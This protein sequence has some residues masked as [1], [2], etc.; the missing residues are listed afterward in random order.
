MSVIGIAGTASVL[1]MFTLAPV[2]GAVKV[3]TSALR[4]AVTLNGVR[5]HQAA[6][7]AHADANGGTREASTPG[8]FASVDYV[9]DAM[10]AA[11]YQVTVQEFLFPFFQELTAAELQQTAPTPTDYPYFD[12]AGFATMTY[13]GSGDVTE[14]AEGVD[15]ILPPASDANTSTSGCE[16]SD[17]D[18]F[19]AG[20]IAVVQRGNCDFVVKAQNAEAAGAVGVIIFNEG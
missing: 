16:A 11:G 1:A 10:S 13:S 14:M 9:A 5:T 8:Y 4:D 3:D 19:T 12:V 15:L 18:G 17:F 20:R 7:Q 2:I 6:F